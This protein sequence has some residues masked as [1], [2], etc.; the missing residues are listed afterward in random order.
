MPSEVKHIVIFGANCGKCKK[1]EALIRSLV[2]ELH[3]NAEVSKCED[4]EVMIKHDV[5]YFPTIMID[6]KIRFKGIVPS[7]KELI[8]ILS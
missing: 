1:A 8:S 5:T 3:L 6:Q 4:W 7:K 2:S